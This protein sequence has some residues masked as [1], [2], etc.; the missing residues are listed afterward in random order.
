MPLQTLGEGAGG[1][2]SVSV[3]E[4]AI[5]CE[6]LVSPNAAMP[7][8]YIQVSKKLKAANHE[9]TGSTA[10]I[11][12]ALCPW[13]FSDFGYS[14]A[15]MGGGGGGGGFFHFFRPPLC[16]LTHVRA[17]VRACVGRWNLRR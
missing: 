1:S 15:R 17:F 6:K 10:A 4:Y 5:R 14:M 9:L 2:R 13:K 3:A 8:T 16:W 11:Y 12:T 7:T